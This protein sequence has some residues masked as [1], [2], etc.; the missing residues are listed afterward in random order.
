MQNFVVKLFD[1]VFLNVI[2]KSWSDAI[3]G[4]LLNFIFTLNTLKKMFFV[5]QR[6]TQTASKKPQSY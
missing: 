6:Q 1:L 5:I 3:Q 4:Y 2:D